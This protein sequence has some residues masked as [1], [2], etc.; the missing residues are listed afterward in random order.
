MQK[1]NIRSS[2]MMKKMLA[3][4]AV[5]V[6]FS[7]V[8]MADSDFGAKVEKLLAHKSNKYFGFKKPLIDSATGSVAR[9]DG[10]SAADLVTV[11]KGLKATILTRQVANKAD[12]FSFWPNEETPTHLIFC[13]EGGTEDLGS[14]LPGSHIAKLNPSVQRINIHTGSVET[15][16]RGMN[17]CDGIRTTA[18][19]TVLATE[20]AGDG[21]GYELIDLLNTNNHTVTD[22]M[23]GAIIDANG[24][25]S[26]TIVKR[27]ALPTMSWEGLTVTEEGVVIGGDEL[28][29][30]DAGEGRDGGAIFKF[31]PETAHAGGLINDLSDSPLVSG[32]TYAL[33]VQCK[34]G[35]SKGF[36]QGCEV[37]GGEWISVNPDTARDDADANGATGYYRPEDL[38][39]DPVYAG[40]G[41]RFCWTNTGREGNQN[42]GE[43]MC[44][45]DETPMDVDINAGAVQPVV[46]RFVEG[47]M[48][49]NS[50]DNL[51]FQPVTGNL[52]VIE[53]HSNGDIFACLPD[54]SDR[55]IK[56]DGCVKVLSV[57]DQ[58]AE[59]TGFGFAANG[60][61]AVLS[62]QHSNDDACIVGTDC[63][64]IDDYGTDDIVIING[65]KVKPY[66][67]GDDEDS[68]D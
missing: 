64:N 20:E 29:P 18:W 44:G 17:R 51:A 38:H 66:Y 49:F 27:A 43:V 12:M 37:G 10:Q 55:N 59:P 3:A 24:V 52:Y 58:S 15:V 65:F 61:I 23:T 4:I 5:S 32:S 62:I 50:I 46:N 25:P 63:E 53:D 2:N 40:P 28:R 6:A 9:A 14:T 30:G 34:S 42:Y 21:Q 39:A 35:G 47:D 1:I 7:G 60:N 26:T 57:K 22:R 36:G 16:L 19:G 67:Y 56:S 68:D 41:L 11:A 45:I 8:S 33:Q 48:D 31:V 54:G 13:I